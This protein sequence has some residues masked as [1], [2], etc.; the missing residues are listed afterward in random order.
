MASN[1]PLAAS[2]GLVVAIAAGAHASEAAVNKQLADKERVAAALENPNLRDM[3]AK[4]LA[5]ADGR[6]PADA[7]G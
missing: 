5:G 3:V 6:S 4:C 7:A 1:P 2:A